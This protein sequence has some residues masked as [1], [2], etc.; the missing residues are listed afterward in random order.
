MGKGSQ[1]VDP[2]D[3]VHAFR[4]FIDALPADAFV[5][6]FFGE[7]EELS[8]HRGAWD[9]AAHVASIVMPHLRC[10][11][12]ALD[13]GCG[14]GRLLVPAARHFRTVIGVDLHTRHD[15]VMTHL[16]RRGASNAVYV[17]FDGFAL[18]VRNA[19][20]DLVY[21]IYVL[22]YAGDLTVLRTLFEE[23]ARVLRP[24]GLALIYF[25]V[26]SGLATDRQGWLWDLADR[27]REHV[28]PWNRPVAW[29]A[30]VNE[31]NLAIPL[32]VAVRLAD[33]AG[34]QILA[35]GRSR[36]LFAPAHW[37]GQR[38]LLLRRLAR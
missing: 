33:H 22:T 14:A 17:P 8:F 25:G 10:T 29:A 2:S 32:R 13:V 34:L 1:I 23:C 21:S 26:R 24:D 6:F 4:T 37:A 36:R 16:R 15:L 35:N 20:V 18:P 12:I 28:P 9:F 27:A 31:K 5:P 38:Y 7:D 3:A 19:C 11:G 30:P